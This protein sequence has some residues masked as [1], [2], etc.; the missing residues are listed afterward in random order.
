MVSLL[1]KKH[2]MPTGSRFLF[3]SPAP[4]GSHNFYSSKIINRLHQQKA[5]FQSS[6]QMKARVKVDTELPWQDA[7]FLSRLKL[8]HAEKGR[9]R[10]VCLSPTMELE[11]H[12]V[13]VV[14]LHDISSEL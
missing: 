1:T 4:Q 9:G 13:S 6:Y 7:F 12:G 3:F 8:N 10:I 2:I 11:K 5:F 14:Q